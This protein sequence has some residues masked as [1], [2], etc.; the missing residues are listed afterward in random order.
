MIKAL[1]TG[2]LGEVGEFVNKVFDCDIYDIQRGDDIWDTKKL[3]SRMKGK[4]LVVHLAA[5]AHPFMKAEG[6][7]EKNPIFLT[8]EDYWKLNF[9]G[10]KHVVECM[11]KAGVKKLIFMSS[12]GVYGFSNGTPYVKYLPIDEEHP[13]QGPEKLTAYDQTKIACEL[14]LLK[15]KDIQACILRL[16]APGL[17]DKRM[18]VLSAGH[19][20]AHVSENNLKELLRLLWEYKGKSDIFNAGDPTTNRMCPDTVS[21]AKEKYPNIEIRM[22]DGTEPLISVDK[23]KKILGYVGESVL[24][25]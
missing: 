24:N 8:D 16:E 5:Y 21:W 11:R 22:K 1:V 13:I 14:F 3:I 9:D 20:F 6:S 2:G 7:T 15:S 25:L 12:G 4:D 23:A 17:L 10:T 19:L 18:Y